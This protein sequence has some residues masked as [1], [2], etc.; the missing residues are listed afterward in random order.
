MLVV[1]LMGFLHRETGGSV[2][3][4]REARA[5]PTVHTVTTQDALWL[6]CWHR[7]GTHKVYCIVLALLAHSVPTDESR[8]LCQHDLDYVLTVNATDLKVVQCFWYYLT[9]PG[10]FTACHCGLYHQNHVSVR[11]L[12]QM[13]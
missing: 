1:G 12:P 4:A 5:L 9:F 2:D 8:P 7:V 11:G 13:L 10:L 6:T 3:A